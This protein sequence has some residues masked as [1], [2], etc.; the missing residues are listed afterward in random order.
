[1]G[2]H[3]RRLLTLG[4][5]AVGVPLIVGCGKYEKILKGTDAEL[6]YKM[7]LEYY[8]KGKYSKAQSLFERELRARG[9]FLRPASAEL[10][11]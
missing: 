1:M 6:Q 7:A 5:L 9:L 2:L 4:V 11:P 3:W 10:P 8:K